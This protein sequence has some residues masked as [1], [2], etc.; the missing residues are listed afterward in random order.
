MSADFNGVVFDAA[1]CGHVDRLV[2]TIAQYPELIDAGNLHQYNRTP[3]HAAAAG[4]HAQAVETLHQLGSKALDRPTVDGWTPLHIAAERGH[5]AVFE[6]LI[7]LGSDAL[8]RPTADGWT[9]MYLAAKEAHMDL[10][11]LQL[12]LGST[13]LD[14]PDNSGW[15]ALYFAAQSGNSSLVEALVRLGS[16]AIDQPA[17]YDWTSMHVAV[18]EGNLSVVETLIRLGSA[19]INQR[20][21]SSP[22][23][24][25]VEYEQDLIAELLVAAGADLSSLAIIQQSDTMQRLEAMTEDRLLELRHRLFFSRTLLAVLIGELEVCQSSRRR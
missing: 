2:S 21:N 18:Q 19:A 12:R 5:R 7:R 14:A 6:T 22:L 1:A 4:G 9:P 13:A 20:G 10:V 3:M 23:L 8:D 25:A 17:S 24:I 16:T 11:E 15:T